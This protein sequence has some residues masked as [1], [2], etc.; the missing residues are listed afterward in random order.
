MANIGLSRLRKRT[1]TRD[2]MALQLVHALLGITKSSALLFERRLAS[3][4]NQPV[5]QRRVQPYAICT[6]SIPSD[7]EHISPRPRTRRVDCRKPV[8]LEAL[9]LKV[10]SLAAR[11]LHRYASH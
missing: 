1:P 2:V 10:E 11:K 4:A 5:H 3:Y 8:Q 9:S 7:D 6:V